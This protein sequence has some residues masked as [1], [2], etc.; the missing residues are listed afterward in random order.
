MWSPNPPLLTTVSSAESKP[1][2]VVRNRRVSRTAERAAKMHSGGKKQETKGYHYTENAGGRKQKQ[3]WGKT[4]L[5]AKHRPP[6]VE[7]ALNGAESEKERGAGV[8][9]QPITG[10]RL[11]RFDLFLDAGAPLAKVSADRRKKTPHRG[12]GTEAPKKTGNRMSAV[13]GQ[14]NPPHGSPVTLHNS[15]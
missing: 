10:L 6:V 5:I 2:R 3:F 1:G 14:L 9:R 4:H 8:A 7:A 13:Q 15:Q 12:H 11:E